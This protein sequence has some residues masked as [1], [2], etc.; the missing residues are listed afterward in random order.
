[1]QAMRETLSPLHQRLVTTL[2]R[3]RHHMLTDALS[4][5]VAGPE[6]DTIESGPARMEPNTRH[7]FAVAWLDLRLCMASAPVGYPISEIH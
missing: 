6:F 1:M 4:W 3:V 7:G 5:C 2:T